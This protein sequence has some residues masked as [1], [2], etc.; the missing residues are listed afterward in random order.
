MTFRSRKNELSYKKLRKLRLNDD[1]VCPF[2]ALKNGDGQVVHEYPQFFVAKNNFP[3]DLWEGLPVDDHLMI[4]PKRHISSL[5]QLTSQERKA[6]MDIVAR[7]DSEGYSVYTR[8]ESNV[9]K[10]VTHLHTHLLKLGNKHATFTLYL[11]KPYIL[12]HN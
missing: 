2:C 10:S 7:Y 9:S 11:S 1:N 8:T 4:I 5:H 12:W 3:Y 6:Y